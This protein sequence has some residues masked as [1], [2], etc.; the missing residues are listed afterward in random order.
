MRPPEETGGELGSQE[1][2]GS[3]LQ[4]GRR[5]ERQRQLGPRGR[6]RPPTDRI[7]RGPIAAV[8]IGEAPAASLRMGREAVVQAESGARR[9]A[10][11]GRPQV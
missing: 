6:T 10:L 4:P 11:K 7:G 2:F 5:V 8:A 3:A 1:G 9:R